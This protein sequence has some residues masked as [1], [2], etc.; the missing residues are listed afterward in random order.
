[1]FSIMGVNLGVRVPNKISQ[2][3]MVVS[4]SIDKTKPY[5]IDSKAVVVL[6]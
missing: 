3:Q 2:T 1:M 6:D 5:S 4:D